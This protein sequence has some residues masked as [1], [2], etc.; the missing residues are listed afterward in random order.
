MSRKEVTKERGRGKEV[1]S[2]QREQQMPRPGGRRRHG[3]GKG[4]A[5][6]DQRRE[7]GSGRAVPCAR[8]SS[9]SGSQH[10]ALHSEPNTHSDIQTVQEHHWSS[11]GV[12]LKRWDFFVLKESRWPQ[13]IGRKEGIPCALPQDKSALSNPYCPS[14]LPHM[15]VPNYSTLQRDMHTN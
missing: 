1:P 13:R 14:P 6:W 10:H 3:A 7:W 4:Y 5:R 15:V 9:L 2:M 12:G 8:L 11:H